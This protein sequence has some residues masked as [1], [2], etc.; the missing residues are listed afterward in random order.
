M[1]TQIQTR[2]LQLAPFLCPITLQCKVLY[3]ESH[4][5]RQPKDNRMT[6]KLEKNKKDIPNDSKKVASSTSSKPAQPE[7]LDTLSHRPLKRNIF[8]PK[9][10]AP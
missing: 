1:N 9:K 8:H 4:L 3:K 2:P 7:Q 6:K 5:L 10:Y